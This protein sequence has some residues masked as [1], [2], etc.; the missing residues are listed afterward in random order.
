MGGRK[1]TTLYERALRVFPPV[2]SRATKLGI[3]RAEGCWVYDENGKAYLDFASGVAVTNTGHNHPAVVQRAA[4]QMRQMIH[5]GH[6]VFYYEP[7]VQLAERL[8][9][10]TGGDTKVYF[11][12]SGAE[13]NEGAVKLVQY[14]TGRPE[15]IAFAHSFH[16]RTLGSLALTGSNAAYRRMY[17]TALRRV[18]FA[19][20]PKPAPGEDPEE[21]VRASL[22]S[23]ND[24][25]ELQVS[26]DRV[27][28]I[29]VEP[30]QGE[31]GYVI[32]PRSFLEKLR[33]ICDEHGILL[34]F[35]EVQTGFGRTGHLFAYQTFGV[36]PDILTL[37]KAIASGFPLSAVIARQDL[38][39][40]WPAGAHGGTFGGNPVSCAAGLATLDLLEGGLIDN[41]RAMGNYLV[42]Q[43]RESLAEFQEVYDVRGVGLMVAVEFR[44]PGS[45]AELS[46]MVKE[47]LARCE[48][49]GLILLSCGPGKTVV[50]FM[51]P[52]IVDKKD[53]DQ[54]VQV[55]RDSVAAA[56]R[57]VN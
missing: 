45:G 36:K 38:M 8:V 47:I 4:E 46:D 39:D 40:R 43:L 57:S 22:E 25:F 30:V 5:V 50:R 2:A 31:G 13:A 16:G 34:I 14:V 10:V 24:L 9:E 48:Q 44:D 33:G 15:V 28:A 17:E 19:R 32:P 7:Y 56:V 41:A 23:I 55:F 18:Y 52:L 21:A 42:A 53:I 26:P 1:L 35:D 11:S 51:P 27:A 37:G 54:A 49:G 6:N 12:N 29:I 20:Y 3:V